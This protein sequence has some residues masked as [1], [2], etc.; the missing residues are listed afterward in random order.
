MNDRNDKIDRSAEQSL[1]AIDDGVSDV[2]RKRRC[3]RKSGTIT[4]FITEE[5]KPSI[6]YI[7]LHLVHEVTSPQAFEGL[8]LA[9]RKVRRPDL[10]FA[11]MDHNVPT[12]DRF[13]ITD[14]ISKQQIDTL[15]KNCREFGIKL[16]DLNYDRSGR[17]ARH[18]T[19]ARADAAGQDDRVRRQPHVDARRVRRAGVRHRHERSRARAGD[20]ML[21]ASEAE[22]DGSALRRQAA[23]RASRRRT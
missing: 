8:R 13:N 11:T 23:S 22:D 10:T 18:G 2:W 1:C 19:G 3:S 20:A 12:K 9:G 17:R 16:F 21:A 4:S 14:P 7:D 5:G 6:L 15:T